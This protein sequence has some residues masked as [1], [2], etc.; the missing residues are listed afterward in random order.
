M[1]FAAR[2]F[3]GS[4][5]TA[6]LS[7]SAAPSSNTESA[8]TLAYDFGTNPTATATG[9]TPP[10]TYSW[11]ISNQVNGTWT[12]NS[13][14]TAA[15]P[16]LHV[17]GPNHGTVADCTLVCTVTDAVTATFPTPSVDWHYNRT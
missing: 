10:Y 6:P 3:L 17:T 14:Q 2:T 4:A 8:S 13:G 1:S 9:G 16:S 15:T 7:A 12:F 11:A 5:G